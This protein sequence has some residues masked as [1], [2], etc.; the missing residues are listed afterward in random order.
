LSREFAKRAHPRS[1]W[2]RRLIYYIASVDYSLMR[3]DAK[4]VAEWEIERIVPCHGDVLNEGGKE[5][6]AS[7]YEWFLKGRPEP[8]VILR[9]KVPLMNFMR[10]I[11]LM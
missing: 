6:W 8:G 3:R 2:A 10:W 4:R 5:A 1:I 7:T 11:F 9:M